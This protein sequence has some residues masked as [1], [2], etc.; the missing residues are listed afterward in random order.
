[1]VERR[2]GRQPSTRTAPAV[3]CNA[4]RRDPAAARRAP[5]SPRSGPRLTG[6]LAARAHAAR[7]RSSAALA[8]PRGTSCSTRNV[9]SALSTT[10]QW[11][12]ASPPARTTT[13]QLPL[14]A[15]ASRRAEDAMTAARRAPFV[16]GVTPALADANDAPEPPRVATSDGTTTTRRANASG[17]G[18]AVK[19]RRPSSSNILSA[20]GSRPNAVSRPSPLAAATPSTSQRG[21]DPASASASA[22]ASSPPVSA[23]ARRPTV[24]SR[25]ADALPASP[26]ISLPAA[27]TTTARPRAGSLRSA[28]S[29]SSTG[30]ASSASATSGSNTTASGRRVD[31]HMLFLR[32]CDKTQ[33]MLYEGQKALMEVVAVSEVEE[34]EV[35]LGDVISMFPPRPLPA[36]QTVPL[37]DAAPAPTPAHRLVGSSLGTTPRPSPALSNTASVR[38][39]WAT[40]WTGDA[41]TDG[42]TGDARKVSARFL[43]PLLETLSRHVHLLEQFVA[44]T[45]APGTGRGRSISPPMRVVDHDAVV[46]DPSRLSPPVG[47]RAGRP[48]S[49]RGSLRVPGSASKS[50]ERPGLAL[51]LDLHEEEAESRRHEEAHAL[52]T[53][54]HQVLATLGRRVGIDLGAHP[55]AVSDLG[56]PAPRP[57]TPG[58]VANGAPV[59]FLKSHHRAAL[60]V[61]SEL[62]VESEGYSTLSSLSSSSSELST[63]SRAARRADPLGSLGTNLAFLARQL[64]P[65]RLLSSLHARN[66]PPP[67]PMP[68]ATVMP[69]PRASAS[70]SSSAMYSDQDSF[71][72]SS[73]VSGSSVASVASLTWTGRPGGVRVKRTPASSSASSSDGILISVSAPR[74]SVMGGRAS[75]GTSPPVAGRPRVASFSVPTAP[76]VKVKSWTAG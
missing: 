47:L 5:S 40:D 58:P 16:R 73:V 25:T 59:N 15:P 39:S 36:I 22:S 42:P 53:Q 2:L 72:S 11:A 13:Q 14:S 56:I 19:P 49:S 35:L 63:G 70:V 55:C 41:P 24:V 68:R 69:L 23:Q 12:M 44:S 28:A 76:V 21:S 26:R 3:N 62:D 20:P 1:M 75:A 32:M 50:T 71:V 46:L 29:S 67:T 31:H 37:T 51:V 7:A 17:S 61:A 27:T 65:D 54:C 34:E 74:V 30:P 18:P 64:P 60:D 57:T 8:R 6:R 9:R 4:H 45:P 33:R 43:I 48:T 52:L 10:R 66:T 38:T